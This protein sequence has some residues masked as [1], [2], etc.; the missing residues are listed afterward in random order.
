MSER[1]EQS[2]G[3]AWSL[4]IDTGGTFTDCVGVDPEGRPVRAKVLSS[5]ALRA[6]VAEVIGPRRVR[7]ESS[8]PAG[9][10]VGLGLRSMSSARGVLVES[11]DDGALV[12]AEPVSL[13]PGETVELRSDEEA[14]VL[15]ARLVTG[16]SRNETLPPIRLRLATTRG[17]N[18]LLERR[19]AKVALFVTSGFGDV[20]AIGDQQR[21][22]LFALDVVKPEPIHEAVVEVA[23]RLDADGREVE[24]LELGT[25]TDRVDELAR[26]GVRSAAVALMHAWRNAEHEI[27][28][29]QLLLA[30][31]FE[32]VSVS[33]ELAPF[34]GL[35]SRTHT[36]V[37][38]AFLAPVVG[39]YLDRVGEAVPA[40]SVMTSAGGLVRCDE[41]RAKDSLLSGPA[42]GVVGAAGA[43]RRSGFDRVISFDMG[44]TSTDVARF[45]GDYEY[46]FEHR[47]GDARILAP[48]LAI[49]TVAAGGGSVC[50]FEHDGLCVGPRSAGADPGPACYGAGGPLTLTD[51]NLL[52][53]RL[54]P[55][56]F[57]VPIDEGLARAAAETVLD[58]LAERTGERPRLDDLLAGFLSIADERMADAIRKISVRR[59]Y[60]PSGYV[61]VAF[62]G[63]G[64]Q[65][66]C[67]VARR[68]GMKTVV[69]PR[70][71]GLLSARGLG[72]AVVERFA[73]SQVLRR[74]DAAEP[75]LEATLDSLGREACE[76][77]DR[78]TDR[79]G[80]AIVRRRIV[81]MRFEGQESTMEIEHGPDLRSS[82]EA[83]YRHVYGHLPAR[84][85]EIESLRVVASPPLPPPSVP[86]ASPISARAIPSSPPP[87]AMFSAHGALPDRRGAPDAIGHLRRA[88][89]GG[90]WQEVRAFERDL[91][92]PGWSC[93][94]PALVLERHSATVVEPGWTARLDEAGAIVLE[95]TDG[96]IAGGSGSHAVRVELLAN[97]LGTI[98]TEMGEAL[99]RTSLSANVKERL[100]FSCAVLDAGGELVVNAPHIP[101]HLGAMGLCVRTVSARIEM[102]EGDTVVT[103]H[104]GLGGSHLPD[105]TLITPVFVGGTLSGYVASRAHHAEIGG[106]RPGSMPPTARCLEEEGVLIRPM[107]LVRDGVA[108]WEG[109]RDLL[110]GARHPTRAVE[111]NLADLNGQLAANR[112][113]ADALAELI[114]QVSPAG[115]EGMVEAIKARAERLVRDALSR[116]GEGEHAAEE[117]LDDGAP[118]RVRISI[119]ASGGAVV[120]FAGSAPAHAGNLN[121]TEAIVG[122]AVL[123]VLRLLV[124]EPIPLNEGIM[125]AVDLRIPPGMLAPAFGDDPARCPAVAAGNVET[126]QRIVDTLVKALRLSAAGQGTM[127]NVLF[128]DEH[129]GYYETIC[130][131]CGATPSAPGADAVHCHMTNTRLTDAEVL[132]HRYP[133]RVE[134]MAIRRDSGGR[135]ERSGGDGVV[136][137]LRFLRPVQVSVV[138]QRRASGP[139]GMDGGGDGQPGR[140]RLLRADGAIVELGSIDAVD[141]GAGDIL[142][143]E[144]PGGGGHGQG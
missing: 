77:V 43:G 12:L 141:A 93:D 88:C 65:H 98:A 125:R 82:F 100:D 25:I 66:A 17:T 54:D 87:L 9:A 15:A 75:G 68:L 107:H 35:L 10:A 79:T 20:L 41:Y 127:N 105:V 121:A 85:I 39:S 8:W 132:E 46:V 23:G 73:Q 113:G 33:S 26:S 96:S 34:M 67:G 81:L 30:R 129:F 45:D 32:L 62:G 130:G 42:G 117:R 95:S 40:I 22:D 18:A 118:I 139:F 115:F 4:W 76:R 72:D 126:S 119:D 106:T 13:A 38:D 78:E 27:A 103:N 136:R 58:R 124:D 120:D 49:E 19:G 50:G 138:T 70:D 122:S 108:R 61:L 47:V 44:G 24:P 37:A 48:A 7:L 1:N 110:L 101:V 63:A 109:V 31:G 80:S 57:G 56:R 69:V 91:L 60:D 29:K 3:G 55:G 99:R 86:S 14:P 133:A 94:G 53:G 83:Q 102:R 135:G 84:E 89:F 74:L 116:L 140:Q 6:R 114:E 143:I 11:D 59:G 90:K 92:T 142:E 64:A 2:G 16:R 104:P 134:I 52:L 112:R 21:P 5:S 111:E 128:G 36:T 137:R 131:G 123:Y 144:T 71:A 51:V 97:R 28:L